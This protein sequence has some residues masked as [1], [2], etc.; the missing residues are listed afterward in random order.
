LITTCVSH[1]IKINFYLYYNVRN[2]L[3]Q[4]I[5]S[6]ELSSVLSG[7]KKLLQLKQFFA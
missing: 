1:K 2:N 7:I 4:A 5:T 3:F 6:L